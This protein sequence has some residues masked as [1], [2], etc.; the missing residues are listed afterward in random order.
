MATLIDERPEEET[1]LGTE[2]TL[3]MPVT[4]EE[5]K[6]P[7]EDIPEKYRGK[8]MQELVQ[9]HQESEKVIGRQGSEVGELRKAFDHHVQ[10][11]LAPTPQPEEEV[12]F[13]ADP[14]K[15]V[16]RAIDQ[17]PSVIGAQQ[18][19]ET[20]R[21]TAAQNAL[22]ARHPDMD[23]I[24]QDK[25]FA[26]WIGASKVRTNMLQKA[27][28]EYDYEQADEL[29]NLWKDR[30]E[31]VNQT[32]KVEEQARKQQV[33]QAST[34]SSRANTETASRKMYRRADII[35]LMKTDPVRYEA[36]AD[37]ILQAYADGRVK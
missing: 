24:I 21:Q 37:E 25:G 26:D 34:G 23:Q 8:T 17:H 31:V 2:E 4:E 13:F 20:M 10:T 29:F 36:M 22:Q 9:M 30:K 14:D 35:K 18:A 27:H 3:E 5:P 7:E 19:A 32:A 1:E 6:D 15:A 12:D 33:K 16:N 11:Q 28:K